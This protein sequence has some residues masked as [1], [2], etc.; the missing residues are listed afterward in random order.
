M[1]WLH[2]GLLVFITLSCCFLTA[3]SARARHYAPHDEIPVVVNKIGPF[4]NPTETYHYYS[5]PFCRTPGKSKKQNLGEILVGDRKVISP[6]EI[7][8]LDNVPWRLLCEKEMSHSELAA[9]VDAID[10]QFYFEMFIDDLP[11]WGYLGEEEGEELLLGNL[12]GARRYLYPHLHFAVGYNQDQVVSVNVSTNPQRKVDITDMADGTQV[13][14]SYSVDWV[15]EPHLAHAD[16]I[17]RYVDNRFLPASFEIHWLS[18]INS[19]VLVLLLMAFLTIILMRVLKNDFTRYMD[20]DEEDMGGEEESGWK[21]LHG[22][23]FRPPGNLNLFTALVG[24]GGQ[25]CVTALS[26]LA[27]ALL[28]VFRATKRGSILTSCIVLYILT[29]FF[30][31]Y[32]SA[33]L[34]KQL[35]GKSWVWNIMLSALAFPAPLLAVF[36][37]VN[38]VAW[39]AASTAALPWHTIMAI[40]SMWLLI[41]FPLHVLGGIIGRNSTSVLETPCRTNKVPREIPTDIPWYRQPPAQMFMAGFLPFSAIYI[42]LHYIFAAVWGHKIYTLF[43]ILFLAF[44]LLLVVTSFITVALIYFQLALEDHRWW[45][46]AFLSG[47]AGGAFIYAYSFFYYYNRSD[48][49]GVLQGSFYFGYMALVS[50]A[51]ALMLGAIG[52]TSSMRFVRY[53]YGVVKVD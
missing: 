29:A 27:C 28:G 39:S 17:S 41:A 50:Y 13:T 12:E 25:L 2:S 49:N 19:F 3:R 11:M 6:Y 22:D 4:N 33:R 48:M 8:F 18:I 31:G 36:S 53:I 5:L 24:A 20:V 37:W 30:G 34:Y 9:F 38:S 26:L 35:D 15:H 21:L 51:F 43:G 32:L 40:M 42:E 23:V 47:G 44:L 45:W 7:T 1:G 16:R 46:R 14:F 52:F 10:N